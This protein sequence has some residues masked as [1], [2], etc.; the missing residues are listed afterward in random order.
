MLL[1]NFSSTHSVAVC[2]CW[3][4]LYPEKHLPLFPFCCKKQSKTR[5]N[6]R[7][8]LP[9]WFISCHRRST[10]LTVFRIN[11]QTQTQV[12][13]WRHSFNHECFNHTVPGKILRTFLGY[14]KFKSVVIT[15]GTSRSYDNDQ[16]EQLHRHLSLSC[17]TRLLNI[18]KGLYTPNQSCSLLFFSNNY[19]GGILRKCLVWNNIF[20]N[21][22]V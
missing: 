5:Q 14:L 2:L 11:D 9:Y 8:T 16:D 21:V 10:W 19:P 13:N 20:H 12:F 15:K 3:Q 22:F 17:T 18:S 1:K 4:Y 6:S 7:I